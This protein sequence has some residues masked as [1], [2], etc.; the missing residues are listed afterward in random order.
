MKNTKPAH[1]YFVFIL[2]SLC[3]LST[4]AQV[5][6]GTPPFGTFGGGPDVINLANLNS[7]VNVPILNK[8]GRGAPFT[9]NL[10]YDTSVWYPVGSSGSQTWTPVYNWGWRGQTEANTGYISSTNGSST[11]YYYVGTMKYVGS[12]H[13]WNSGFVYH[14]AWGVP[15]PFAGTSNIYTGTGNGGCYVGPD[16]GFTSTATDG[17]GYTISVPTPPGG[18]TTVASKSGQVVTPPAGSGTGAANTT[19]TNGNQIT[20][21]SSGQ[22]YDTL[23]SSTPV[24]TV[25]GVSPHPTT[26]TYTAP[27]GSSAQYNMKQ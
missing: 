8:A 23:S 5:T 13:I 22:F 15:P 27:S 14:D 19:E 3:C 18:S 26:F 6:T 2:I 4:R 21:N 16:N 20:I 12:I 24:L 9:Y 7:H 1:L 25:A 11:C 17:S 10:S